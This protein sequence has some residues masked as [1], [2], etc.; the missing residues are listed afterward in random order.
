MIAFR[1]LAFASLAVVA[2][3]PAGAA[4][5][6]VWQ[7]EAVITS[8]TAACA[9]G[10]PR[11][12]I[13]TGAVLKSIVRPKLVPGSSNG[14][15]SRIAFVHD[16]MGEMALNLAAGLA[17]TGTTGSYAAYGSN[18]AGVLKANVGGTYGPMTVS[19]ASPTVSNTFLKVTGTVNN[20]MFITNCTVA[21]RAGYVLRQ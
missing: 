5:Y 7:G 19:V 20:F 15:D 10:S 13:R 8:A 18:S 11:N 3:E 17:Y 14:N 9:T 6:T 21:F 12:A 2:A 16:M 1:T 4:T